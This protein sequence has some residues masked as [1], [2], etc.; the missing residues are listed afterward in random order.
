MDRERAR[1]LV[2]G[3]RVAR[4]GTLSTTGRVDLVPITF[5]VVDDVLYTA[6]DHKPKTTTHLK[7]LENVRANPEVGVLVDEYDDADWQRLWWV[8]LRGLAEVIERGE[9]YERALDA[10]VDKYEQ[11]RARR[12]EGPAIAVQLVRWQWWSAS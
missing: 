2:S 9:R 7:R 12:P 5:A 10:L 11:Y 3:A 1:A 4:L 8:R 6:V